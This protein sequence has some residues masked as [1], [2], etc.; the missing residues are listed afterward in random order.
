MPL[1]VR[2]GGRKEVQKSGVG[3]AVGAFGEGLPGLRGTVGDRDIVQLSEKG[4]GG[5]GQQLA[6]SGRQPEEG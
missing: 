1:P 2:Q 3:G 5:G 6:R 4:A